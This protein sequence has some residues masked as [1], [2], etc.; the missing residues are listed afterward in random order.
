M[1]DINTTMPLIGPISS[2]IQ[3]IFGVVSILV[4]GIFGIYVI[5]LIVRLFFFRKIYKSF[6]EIRIS[7]K[8]LED[9]IDKLGKKKK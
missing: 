2:T 7:I 9:K 6:E 4:G 3:Q 5:T 8:R 1:V